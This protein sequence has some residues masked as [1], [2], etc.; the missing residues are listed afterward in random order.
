MTHKELRDAIY[1]KIDELPTIPVVVAKVLAL[2]EDD[3]A[4]A[5]ALTKV[6]SRDPALTAKVLKVA[7]SAYYGFPQT[8]S[9]LDRAV[10]LLGMNMVQSLALSIGV[11]GNLPKSREPEN[12]STQGLWLHSLA[13]ATAMDELKKYC[14]KTGEAE[15]FFVVGLLHDVGK[16]VLLHF[17]MKEYEKAL[18]QLKNGNGSTLYLVE[19][20]AIGFDHGQVGAM[21]LD[22][23]KFPREVI[24]PIAV[25]HHSKVPESA[26]PRDASMLKVADQVARLAGIGHGDEKH[27]PVI[28]DRDLELLCLKQEDL[29]QVQAKIIES[30]ESIESFFN[31]MSLA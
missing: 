11:L 22:R 29:A 12:F 3:K 10:A 14:A 8:I 9:G 18:S 23:W 21:L 17:F 2:I 19:R 24:M 28:A 16:I 5:Q 25:H 20:A 15:Y 13:V 26:N 30:K 1:A 4:D 31:S 6:I 7:N 27:P